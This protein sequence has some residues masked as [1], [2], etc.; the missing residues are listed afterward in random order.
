M[1]CVF[2]F[3]GVLLSTFFSAANGFSVFEENGKAGLRNDQGKVVIPA[4]FE[5]LGWSDGNFSVVNAV[6]GYKLNGKWGIITVENHTVTKP[7]FEDIFPADATLIFARKKSIA[8]LRIVTGCLNASGKEIIPFEYDGIALSGFR[9]IVFTKV[10]NQY[11]YGLIDLENKT[12]IPQQYSG[13]HSIGSLRYAVENFDNKVALFTENGKQ[14]T[15]FTID[16]LS[17]FK[18]D[19]AVIYQ[20]TQQGLIDRQGQIKLEP[21]YRLVNIRDDGSVTA[22]QS[23]DWLFLDGQNKL[24]QKLQGDSVVAIGKNLLKVSTAGLIQLEDYA[25]KPFFASNFSSLGKFVRGKTLFSK[26]KKLGVI[27]QNGKILIEAKYDNLVIDH[28]YYITNT[29]HEGK[30]NWIVLDSLGKPLHTKPYS[31]ILPFTGQLFPVV[32]RN[33]WGAINATGK[34]VVACTYDS[35]LQQLHE[36]MVVKFHGQYGIINQREEWKVTPRTSKLRL[37][38]ADRFVERA[39][40]NTYLKSLDGNVIYFSENPMVINDQHI[41]EQLPSGTLWEIDLNGVIVNRQVQ[42]EGAIEKIYPASEGLRAIKKNGQF[43]F[44][45]A[46]GRL[47]VANR[48]DGIQPFSESLAAIKIRGKWGFIGHDDHIAIQPVYEEVTPF[49]NGFSLVKQKGFQ[50]VIDKSGALILPVRYE[51]VSILPHGNMLIQQDK[52]LGLAD[53]KGRVLIN[54]KYNS[55]EDLNNNYVIVERDGQYGVITLQGI[56]TIPLMYDH[57][58]YDPYNNFFIAL[59][60]AEWKEI[61]L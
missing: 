48:Y 13:I 4:R 3:F 50:G 51:R 33:Y 35:I 55:L 43:G 30:D 42:P 1:K 5:K 20:G 36:N 16:S 26:D 11:R 28:P 23:D 61:K 58:G 19:Y 9:A 34:E 7:E 41:I 2:C 25:L 29:R 32:V 46:Q 12:L 56:S 21:S 18:K 49:K 38:S 10:G 59:K 24:H 39:G 15:G 60:K 47:R 53:A 57:I 17:L 44:V 14:V 27:N 22:R 6:T 8:S 54:P 45:D 31:R 52:L 37:V 40:K